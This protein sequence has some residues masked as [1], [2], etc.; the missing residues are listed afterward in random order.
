MRQS[1][2]QNNA[3]LKNIKNP[4]NSRFSTHGSSYCCEKCK[5]GKITSDNPLNSLSL[6]SC[7]KCNAKYEASEIAAK[8]KMLQQQIDNLHKRSPTECE[9]FLLKSYSMTPP[10]HLLLVEIKYILCLLYGNISEF[11]Y[12][13]EKKN[14][15]MH[16]N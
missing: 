3:N 10:N 8:L 2:I 14:I 1:I 7:D 4:I 5:T 16:L 11:Q 15:E 12:K 6:W 13:G 9:N